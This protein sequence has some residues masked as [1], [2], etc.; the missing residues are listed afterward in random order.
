[1]DLD[2]DRIHDAIRIAAEN[3]RHQ[4]LDEN[5]RISV[6]VDF[7]RTPTPE[8]QAMIEA[9]VGFETQFRYWLIDAIAGTIELERLH[10]LIKLPR[11]VFVELDG[12]LGIQ[13][14]DVVPTPA[15]TLMAGYE[16]HRW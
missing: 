2:G 1:M 9:E 15:S 4:Y 11:V 10:D 3:N 14:Q 13:M 5:G 6:I 16:E 12:L 7:D 8:D